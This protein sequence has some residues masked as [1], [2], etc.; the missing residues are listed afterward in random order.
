MSCNSIKL[1]ERKDI[2]ATV[3]AIPEGKVSTY[4][5]VAA[6]AG[7]PGA[8]RAVGNALH[9]NTSPETVPCHRVVHTDGSLGG[10]YAFGGPEAQKERLISEGVRFIGDKVDMDVCLYET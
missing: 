10:N 6:A 8:A 4:G 7:H 5:R 2:F 1:L 3:A 9:T